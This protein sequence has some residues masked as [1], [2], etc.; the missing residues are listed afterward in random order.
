MRQRI[1]IITNLYPSSTE[2][3]RGLYIKQLVDFLQS[4]YEVRV[5]APVPWLPDW[6]ARRWRP[7][8]AVPREESIQGVRVYHPRYLAIP[9]ILRFSHGLSFA[10]CIRRTIRRKVSGYRFDLISVHW[11]FPDVFGTVLAAASMRVPIV[12]HALGCDVNDYLRYPLR[13]RMIRWALQRTS[14]VVAKSEEI[15]AKVRAL[16]IGDSEVVA[17]HNGVN[18]E[19][20]RLRD[21]H[22]QRGS[23][24]LPTGKKIILF[25][26]N[27][28]PEKGVTF[29]LQAVGQLHHRHKDIFLLI[30]GDGPLRRQ[31]EEELERWGI[32]DCTQLA[33]SVAHEEI[34]RYL[35]SADVLCLP[36]LREGCPNVVL[37]SLA[38]GTPVVASAVGAIP[39][40]MAR[41]RIGF[42]TQP[43]NV[44]GL[45]TAM[46]QALSLPD[47]IDRSFD[48]FSWDDNARAI[49]DVFARKI[50]KAAPA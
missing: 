5:I 14:A 13:R 23:L 25:I 33:G 44:E 47:D 7:T 16:G 15:A 4:R 50:E 22:A 46:L 11:L 28:A 30:V 1:L 27:L 41:T 19:L 38:S 43:G 17:I 39:E 42:T 26:G 20:F 18:R 6:A 21:K 32:S 37:E 9:K 45:A 10:L 2:P 34:P 3:V 12:A 8:V 48:W 24:M 31:V 36:S 49:S 29:M 35:N 40:M